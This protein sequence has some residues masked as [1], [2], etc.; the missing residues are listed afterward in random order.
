MPKCDFNIDAKQLRVVLISTVGI[1]C[2]PPKMFLGKGVLKICRKSTGED[3]CRSV[4]LVRL[5]YNFIEITL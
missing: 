5:L 1:R 4:N 3:L 2:S